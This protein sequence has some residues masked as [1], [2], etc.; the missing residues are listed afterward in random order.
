MDG[1]F[2]AGE[3]NE[4]RLEG[5]PRVGFLE[6]WKEVPVLEKEIEFEGLIPI[7]F[8]NVFESVFADRVEE[9]ELFNLWD[10]GVLKRFDL[11]GECIL[12]LMFFSDFSFR[13]LLQDFIVSFGLDQFSR[14]CIVVVNVF[15]KFYE[16]ELRL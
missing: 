2:F 16:E 9:L 11:R 8:N 3:S 6:G 14:F 4:F 5:V 1:L 7:E 10:F 12:L 15:L 13:R